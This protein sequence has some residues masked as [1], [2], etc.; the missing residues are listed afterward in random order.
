MSPQSCV[1]VECVRRLNN[2]EVM[3]SAHAV[4]RQTDIV[5]NNVPF[6]KIHSHGLQ[7]T[8]SRLDGTSE[9]THTHTHTAENQL[10]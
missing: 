1:L 9:K 5:D 10:G 2:D 8:A 4:D 3:T 6:P 7:T